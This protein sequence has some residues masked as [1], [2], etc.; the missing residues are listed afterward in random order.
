M[1]FTGAV[2]VE[3][4]SPLQLIDNIQVSKLKE[5]QVLMKV[6]YAGV[7]HSQLMEQSGKRGEDKIILGWLKGDGSD[8]QGAVYDSP[9]GKINSGAVTTF[10]EYTAVSENRC[11]PLPNNLS[12][13]E[14]V[15]LGC[16]LPKGRG[17]ITNQIKPEKNSTLGFVGLGGIGMSALI[18]ATCFS[19]DTII[20][21]D[22][23]ED[24]LAKAFALGATHCIN[25]LKQNIVDEVSKITDGKMLDYAIEAADSCKTIENAF[26]L[27]NRQSGHCIFASHPPV[28]Q[29]IQIDPFE[30][31]CGK[32]SQVVGVVALTQ[33]I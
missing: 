21:I 19:C 33:N 14:S 20:A 12:I 23:N 11:Y 9:I 3:T 26:S 29:K 2:L 10:S 30:L 17:I 22:T 28:G 8:V 27:I 16:P 18:D 15:L 4:G 13:Q 6:V 7:C 31:I 25:P 1:K 24:K 5:G 32:K